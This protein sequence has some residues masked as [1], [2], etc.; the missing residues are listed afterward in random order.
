MDNA[1]NCDS[2]IQKLPALTCKGFV[3]DADLE[4][5]KKLRCFTREWK[6]AVGDKHG[7]KHKGK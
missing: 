5:S 2:Y 7:N 1:H 4:A 3:P 6:L